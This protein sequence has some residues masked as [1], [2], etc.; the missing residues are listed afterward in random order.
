MHARSWNLL[1]G[2]ALGFALIPN[3]HAVGGC[4]T[5]MLMGGYGMQFS[6]TSA[7]SVAPSIGGVSVPK[8]VAGSESSGTTPSASVVGSAHLVMDGSGGLMG[9]SAV[10]LAGTWLQGNVTGTYTVNGDCTAS[11]A[12]MDANGNADNFSGVIVNEGGSALFTQTDAGSG[13]AGTLIP[14]RG[15]CQT[16]DLAGSFGI[17]YAGKLTS[18]AGTPYNSTGIL[19]LDGSGAVTATESRITGGVFSQVAS[20]GAITVNDDCSASMMLT[21]MTD[22]KSVNFW[23]SLSRDEKTL[24]LVQSDAGTAASGSM[25]TQ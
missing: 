21:S 3:A 23:G 7:P 15:F 1:A 6:G 8:S 14:L 11:L 9:Y 13:V 5:A 24:M 25:Q 17:Q 18:T 10:N 20:S 16:S 19:M 4:S 2:M 22:G 12:I